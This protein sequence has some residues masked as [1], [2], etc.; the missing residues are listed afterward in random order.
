[1]QESFQQPILPIGRVVFEDS[2]KIQIMA[3]IFQ[4]FSKAY[5]VGD[6]TRGLSRHTGE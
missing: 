3:Q 2:K 5:P 4:T 1:M 6:K